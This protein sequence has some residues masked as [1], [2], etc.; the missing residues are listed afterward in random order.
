MQIA[1]PDGA[2]LLTSDEVGPLL[3]AAVSHAG[4]DLVS[5]SLDHVDANPSQS[6]TATYSALID[7]PYG[8]REE[9]LGVSARASG[10]SE[11]DTEA[12]IFGDGHREV[13]VWIYPQDPDLPGLSRAAYAESMAEVC[14]SHQ[15][16]SGRV[17]PEDLRLQMIG[18]RPRRPS[19]GQGGSSADRRGRLRQGVAHQARRR[20]GRTTPAA[21]RRGSAGGA[22][23]SRHRGP[24]ADPEGAARGVAGQSHLR[25]GRAVHGRGAHRSAGRDAGHRVG[26]DQA[27]SVVGR[28]RSLRPRGGPGIALD[29]DQAELAG[30]GDPLGAGPDP[31]RQR[32]D[33]RRLPRGP[34]ARR[35]RADLRPAGHRHPSGPGAEPTTWP[36]WWRTCPRSS[37]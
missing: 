9:L 23:R 7:W 31:A 11:T 18:Y 15:V 6:T 27:S 8:R 26:A 34:G 10:P 21:G 13:A 12:E 22:D 2:V 3:G 14:N 32:A 35:G 29:G 28:G 33:P 24:P 36:A 30:R 25:S 16:F 4:G 17:S 1:D 19:R 5:W 37:G 20:S